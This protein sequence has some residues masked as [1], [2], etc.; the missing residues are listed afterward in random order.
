MSN[1]LSMSQMNHEI[2]VVFA[3]ERSITLFSSFVM[4]P[5]PEKLFEPVNTTFLSGRCPESGRNLFA[6]GGSTR[7]ITG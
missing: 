6:P 3:G 2:R 4:K 1:I 7:Q 5:E